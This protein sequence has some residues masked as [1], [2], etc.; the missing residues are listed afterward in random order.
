MIF[1]DVI[2]YSSFTIR[3]KEYNNLSKQLLR[4]LFIQ[5]KVGRVFPVVIWS[6]F[7]LGQYRDDDHR[8]EASHFNIIFTLFLYSVQWNY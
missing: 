8:D 4:E 6:E 3:F 7:R 5:N 2:T 1:P